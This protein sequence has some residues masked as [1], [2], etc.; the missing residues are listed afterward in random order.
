MD[1]HEY[2]YEN[3]SWNNELPYG[4]ILFFDKEF[5]D[6]NVHLGHDRGTWQGQQEQESGK[7]IIEFDRDAINLREARDKFKSAKDAGAEK[8]KNFKEENKDILAFTLDEN[9]A[10]LY[11][12][13]KDKDTSDIEDRKVELERDKKTVDKNL[14]SDGGLQAKVSKIQTDISKIPHV[15]DKITISSYE[16][17]QALFKYDIKKQA[18]ID[19]DQGIINKIKE[20][21]EFF[22]TGLQIRK[23]HPNKCPFCQS[24]K[25]EN[26]IELVVKVYDQLY[27]DSYKQQLKEIQGSKKKLIIELQHI[28]DSIGS[29]NQNDVFLE[30][31][32]LDQ[33]YNIKNIYSVEEEKSFK[34]L[35]FPNIALLK[36]NLEQSHQPERE[37]I[38][39]LFEKVTNEY[40]TIVSYI[41]EINKYIDKKNKILD[42]FKAENTDEKLANRIKANT[43]RLSTIKKELA[44]IADNKLTSQ[45]TKDRKIADLDALNKEFEDYQGKHKKAREQYEDYCSTEAFT[46]ILSKIQE[47]FAQFHF[48]FTLELDSQRKRGTTKEFPFAFKVMD[49]SGE[50]R[51]L[52]EGLSEG[53]LQVLSLCFFFAFLDVQKDSQE[54]ILIFDDP[55]TSLDNSNLS[56]LVEIIFEVS[57]NFSQT[58]IFT[59]HRMFFKFLRKRC[60]K[61]SGEYNIIRNQEEFGG[62]FICLSKPERFINKLRHFEEHLERIAAESL[63]IELKIVEYGQYLRYEVERFIKNK[64]LHWDAENNFTLAIDGV[65]SNKNILDDD[66]DKIKE[67]YSFCNWT[68]SHVDVGD[69]HGLGQL[70]SKISD[71]IRI[72]E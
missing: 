56:S 72:A 9:D 55:I 11:A 23:T 26:N 63:D 5:V 45:R 47:Y 20:H 2:C 7:L 69:D 71:F 57:M 31:K 38:K 52:K 8:I 28:E 68:T 24:L 70:K 59:H 22:E 29:I 42:N 36:S 50:E 12:K 67:I 13:L 60:G 17:Y 25:V 34:R 4:S 48:D 33:H 62:S 35:E 1:D 51:D 44:F 19:A 54:N 41:E 30:L 65:K 32:R 3:R 58:F 15:D 14:Q 64:L 16:Q 61:D 46:K 10:E 27:D 39:G 53:E 66:L 40:L 18:E 43:A 37:D 6:R 21:K 49:K